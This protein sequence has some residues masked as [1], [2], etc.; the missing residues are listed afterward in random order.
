VVH[1][2]NNRGGRSLLPLFHAN[3]MLKTASTDSMQFSIYRGAIEKNRN[4]ATIIHGNPS[5]FFVRSRVN[6]INLHVYCGYYA[7]DALLF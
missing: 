2:K 4:R 7:I 5:H 1:C 6:E 3:S